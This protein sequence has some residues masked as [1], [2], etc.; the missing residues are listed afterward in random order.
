[1]HCA[2]VVI[3]QHNAILSFLKKILYRCG[4]KARELIGESVTGQQ[5]IGF[6]HKRIYPTGGL[7]LVL[8]ISVLF[9]Y[10][11]LKYSA[12]APHLCN[13]SHLSLTTLVQAL[14]QDTTT[15]FI[16][17]QSQKLW[18]WPGSPRGYVHWTVAFTYWL[19]TPHLLGVWTYDYC[20]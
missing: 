7:S 8:G 18:I 3:A 19:P 2:C 13:I 12:S 6:L 4:N 10:S 1:M 15:Y 9:T 20:I 16:T 11:I 14:S 17:A 5:F